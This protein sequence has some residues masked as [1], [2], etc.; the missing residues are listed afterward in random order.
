M[1]FPWSFEKSFGRGRDTGLVAQA[2][3]MNTSFDAVGATAGGS[4]GAASQAMAAPPGA[5]SLGAP[6]APTRAERSA[7]RLRSLIWFTV[8][9]LVAFVAMVALDLQ[10]KAGDAAFAETTGDLLMHSQRL[11][12]AAPPAIHG[13]PAA[14]AQMRESRDRLGAGLEALDKGGVVGNRTVHATG[15]AERPRLTTVLADWRD[16][17]AASGVIVDNEALLTAVGAALRKL[18]DATPAL[19]EASDAIA[20]QKL[21]VGAPPREVAMAGQLQ[22][23]TQRLSREVNDLLA[24]AGVGPDTAAALAR[25]LNAYRE[26]IDGLSN[27]ARDPDSRDRL[28]ALQ[29]S[30]AGYQAQ[31]RGVLDALPKLAG[32]RQAAQAVS[33]GSEPMRLHLAELRNA[34]SDAG[35]VYLWLA[36]V[37]GLLALLGALLIARSYIAGAALGASEAR[38]GRTEAERQEEALKAANEAN[39]IAILRLMNELQEVADGNLTMQATVSEDI[40]GAIADSVNY[41]VEELRTLVGRINSTVQQVTEASSAAQ[42]TSSRLLTASDAQSREIRSTGD[43]VLTMARQISDVSGSAAESATVARQSLA[44]AEDG[45][46]AVQNSISGM[47]EIRDQIQETSKRIKRLGE[48]SQE[49]GEI[50]ELISDITEQTNVLALNAAIQAASA[51]EAGRGFSVVAE[52]VQRL[53]ERSGEATKQIGALVRTI[54]T[55]TQDAVSAMEKSTEGV[56]E[57]AKLSDAAGQSLANIGR[58]SRQLAELI[59]AISRNTSRQ[60]TSAGQMASSIERILSVN[61]Q[62]SDGTRRT[63]SSIQQLSALALELKNSVARFKVQ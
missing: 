20:A 24:G 51:G 30:F 21:Q 6:G 56:V 11:A 36:L 13:D 26:T 52:E 22:L 31:M 50:I 7:R 57:G 9:M 61:E 55:D 54:Q 62:A 15:A 46:R 10:G 3:S 53:A 28:A 29:K 49:I 39:Q 63:A 27:A 16:M 32:T 38:L 1:A 58:V 48:S 25:D 41:T 35:S 33:A 23:L 47:N 18:S 14:L 12:K 59:E 44:A 40:T 60:A 37:S 45:Q 43:A 19:A 5:P 34:V 17:H 42:D 2:T 8:A 4:N